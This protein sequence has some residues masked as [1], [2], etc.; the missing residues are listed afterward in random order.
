MIDYSNVRG[1]QFE[2]IFAKISDAILHY[3]YWNRDNHFFDSCCIHC[4]IIRYYDIPKD[5]Y[6]VKKEYYE[7][8]F[9]K[10]CWEEIESEHAKR[11][12]GVKFQTEKYVYEQIIKEIES[13]DLERC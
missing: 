11:R 13:S 9:C 5:Y 12:K 10:D 8:L 4:G 1:D 6:L 2:K 7:L 3:P